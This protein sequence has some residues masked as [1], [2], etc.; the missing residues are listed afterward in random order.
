MNRVLFQAVRIEYFLNPSITI[1]IDGVDLTGMTNYALHSH[2][3]FRGRRITLPVATSGYI[4]HLVS[5]RSN[6]LNYQFEASPIESFSQ[7]NLFH[8]YEVGY[9]GSG[10]L[11]PQIYLDGT[12]QQATFGIK[13]NNPVTVAT[14]EA[15]DT[16]RVYFDPLAYGYVPHIHN[17]GT[18]DVDAEILWARPVALPPRFYRGLRTHS[19]FQITFRGTVD[20]EWYLDGTSIGVYN[21]SSTNT[22]TEKNYFPSG[23][24]GHVIQYIHENPEDGGKVYMVETDQ[25]LADLEQQAMQPQAEG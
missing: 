17:I 18:S 8:Y 9:R 3:T 4:G 7:Q 16:V 21:F 13:N 15:T 2:S 25:T 20:I 1:S 14:T 24:I 10:A 19:E 23:T 12:T 5:S 11:R 22:V 6:L